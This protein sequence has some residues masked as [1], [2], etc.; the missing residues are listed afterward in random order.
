MITL[1]SGINDEGSV[2]LSSSSDLATA[3]PRDP[4]SIRLTD[5]SDLYQ[6]NEMEEIPPPD[7][8]PAHDA[9]MEPGM[10]SSTTTWYTSKKLQTVP[11]EE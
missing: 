1:R 9:R 10:D 5:L 8:Y 11:E 4:S 2:T 7:S 6:S 3:R